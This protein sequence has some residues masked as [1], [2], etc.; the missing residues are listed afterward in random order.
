M[1]HI[2]SCYMPLKSKSMYRGST[3]NLTSPLQILTCIS[4]RMI[5]TTTMRKYVEELW[6]Q[7]KTTP[8]LS[9]G[10]LCNSL[11][12]GKLP[13]CSN[14]I[15]YLPSLQEGE[16]L[17]KTGCMKTVNCMAL[18]WVHTRSLKVIVIFPL[19]LVDRAGLDRLVTPYFTQR[20][21]AVTKLTSR[22]SSM[23][24]LICVDSTKALVFRGNLAAKWTTWKSKWASYENTKSPSKT[25]LCTTQGRMNF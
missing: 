13:K 2:R 8:V 7:S 3:T 19:T 5:K 14:E 20:D 21:G 25:H 4:S 24:G 1:W 22:S 10:Q 15:S 6:N 11:H 18:H 23:Q 9:D 16:I 12:R 17:K